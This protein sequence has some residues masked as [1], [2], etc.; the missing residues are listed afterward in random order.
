MITPD[1]PASCVEAIDYANQIALGEIPACKQVTNA[2]SR[3]FKDV[4]RSAAGGPFH[5]DYEAADRVIWFMEQM[6]HIKGPEAGH[7]IYL[8][9]WQK[10]IIMNAFGWR[11]KQN[12]SR[13]FRKVYIEVP[14]GNGKSTMVAPI[15]LYML[16]ADGEGG[17]EV[18]SGA[19]VRDQARIVFNAAK[20]MAQRRKKFMQRA[21]VSTFA[22]AIA[23]DDT[24]STF[25][26]ISSDARTLDG[27]NVHFA[28]LDELAQ[29]KSREVHDVMETAT[30]K[31]LQAMLYMIT[32]AGPDQGGIGFE[33]HDYAEKV[34]D[35]VVEDES[36]FAIIYTIDPGDDWTQRTSWIKA[37][38]NWGHS[39]MPDA[40]EA[41]A[42]RA[43]QVPSFQNAF[44]MKHLNIW[45]NA[46][47]GWMDS[48]VWS[49]QA[50]PIDEQE[51]IGAECMMALDLASKVDIA[52]NIKIFRQPNNLDVSAKHPYKYF[53]VPKLYIPEGAIKA[54][55]NNNYLGWSLGGHLMVTPGDV[56]DF[57]LIEEDIM[58]D[59]KKF[60]VQDVAFDPW[61][62]TQLAQRLTGKGI[63]M[64]EFPATV[65]NFSEPTKEFEA[66][67]RQGL[68]F[69]NNN[70]VFNW[71]ISN[72]VVK[73][74]RKGNIFPR[75]EREENKIDG[76]VA[77]IMAL[78][79]WL[80]MVAEEGE[81]FDV[82]GIIG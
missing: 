66:L 57:E 19:V 45:T 54:N 62:A 46:S 74:D 70:P 55:R 67:A 15:G 3:F 59:C 47:E 77:A 43:V 52:A 32:T 1:T 69:H 53:I 78:A 82:Q 81:K 20:A 4:K 65:R 21:G 34:I 64:I 41:L 63:P 31:R 75:K 36:F 17:A 11:H 23:Q 76:P 35:G 40:I 44:K 58:E 51:F 37:N 30:G 42:Q 16:A 73:E 26:P 29:H 10:F 24:N 71:M 61:Q 6:P 5:L 7:N 72:L 9:P 50:A 80:F 28:I 49:R 18:Y 38:P 27:L 14:R 25:M 68:L 12:G 39:V 48:I 13:R 8:A 2:V 33:V 79:R 22:H 60:N 56:I